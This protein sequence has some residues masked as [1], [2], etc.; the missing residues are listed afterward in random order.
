M[1]PYLSLTLLSGLFVSGVTPVSLDSG[2][3]EGIGLND[4]SHS[5]WH[6]LP[7][8][9][10]RPEAILLR[11]GT[12]EARLDSARWSS[13]PESSPRRWSLPPRPDLAK[14]REWTKPP[15]GLELEWTFRRS[16][17]DHSTPLDRSVFAAS[18]DQPW[19]DWFSLGLLGGVERTY[20]KFLLDSISSDPGRS[21]WPWFGGRACVRSACWEFRTSDHPIPEPLWTREN[22]DALAERR[23]STGEHRPWSPPPPRSEFNWQN[24]WTARVGVV[25]WR[26]TV[27]GDRFPGAAHELAVRTFEG[28]AFR[29]TALLGTDDTRA[30]TGF[31]LGV[32]PRSFGL[33]G[34][35]SLESS[36][37]TLVFRYSN[38][39]NL[40]LELRTSLRL[41][42][43][44]SLP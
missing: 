39:Y 16:R 8:D 5:H 7:P 31:A 41:L 6:V 17:S 37:A 29:C 42:Q 43:P 24:S 33:P 14:L 21:W 10:G 35:T 22:M 1:I 11:D 4:R 13:L 34:N 30:W 28:D 3:I 15:Q 9:S 26:T 2:Q 38:V 36:P 18:F 27:D 12:E 20:T 19:D 25:S 40:S 23:D 32:V 44:W